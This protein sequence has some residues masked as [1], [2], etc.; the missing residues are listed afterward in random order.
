M[1]GDYLEVEGRTLLTGTVLYESREARD[2]VLE[3]G[4]EKGASASYDRL[5]RLLRW[6]ARAGT[7]R[8]WLHR[9]GSALA[10]AFGRP[11]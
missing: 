8:Q 4:M 2:T 1:R 9:T 7:G 5:A 6:R 11:G 3:S 10:T